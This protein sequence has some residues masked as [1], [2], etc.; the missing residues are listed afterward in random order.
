MEDFKLQIWVYEKLKQLNNLKLVV[1][2]KQEG[3]YYSCVPFT[4]KEQ[5]Q[6]VL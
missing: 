1:K 6:H 2:I 5:T 4:D 3:S